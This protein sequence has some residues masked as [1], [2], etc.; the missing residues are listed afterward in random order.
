[1][2]AFRFLSVVAATAALCGA[3]LTASAQTGGASCP[4]NQ[5][6]ALPK[7]AAGTTVFRFGVKGGSLRPWSVK[8]HLGGAIDSTGATTARTTLSDTKNTLNALLALADAQGFFAMKGT[9][10]CLGGAGNPDVSTRFIS[11]HTATGTKT[12]QELGSC[13]ATSKYDGL[14]DMAEA[15]SG[16]GG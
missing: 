8:L 10:G 3:P 12:V 6:H 11:I 4:T 15:L 7:G 16:I 9:I 14:F 13:S 1:M 2:K 5:T